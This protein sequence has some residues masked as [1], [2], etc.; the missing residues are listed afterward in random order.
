VTPEEILRGMN[1]RL[2]PYT[3]RD[4]HPEGTRPFSPAQTAML[5]RL[6]ESENRFEARPIGKASAWRATA[7]CLCVRGV[8][9]KTD[10]GGAML[11][12]LGVSVVIDRGMV[13]R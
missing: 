7:D 8:A 4:P 3:G 10:N 6:Y 11:T 2:T 5:V 13:R 9:V 12:M 1:S